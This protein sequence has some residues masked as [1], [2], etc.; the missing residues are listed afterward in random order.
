MAGS[1]ADWSRLTEWLTRQTGPSV[2]VSWAD[3]NRLVGGLP[4]SATSHY[5]QWWHGDRP[6]TRAWRAAGYELDQ[7]EVGRW[8][9][10][11]RVAASSMA[12]ARRTPVSVCNDQGDTASP[13]ASG[14]ALS[15][16]AGV[17]PL[18]ALIVLQCSA[19]KATG[20]SGSVPASVKWRDALRQARS[21]V[22]T[23]AGVDER[24]LMPAWR[25]YA[26][27]FYTAAGDALGQAVAAGANVV[28]LSGG[29]GILHADE[30][31]GVYDRV[32]RLS[33]WPPG[34]LAELLVE[35]ATR[36]RATAVVAFTGATT[37]YGRLVRQTPWHRAHVGQVSLISV[38]VTGG[39]A[40]V[41]VPRGL[42]QA[43]RCFWD[44]TGPWPDG[45]GVESL[46]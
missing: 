7:V 35:E 4:A 19:R 34:L 43:F 38:A 41:K 28:I 3:L 13:V 15:P 10:F 31:V 18:Q 25:R 12:Q 30:P 1:R 36:V 26:G 22:R 37:D 27:G 44:P 16:L 40:M 29:Y 6:N 17:D 5:P 20:G 32:F 42:G 9:T 14:Y 24:W 11:H 8:V 45:V 46:R 39:G 23:A 21:N 2:T 33:D